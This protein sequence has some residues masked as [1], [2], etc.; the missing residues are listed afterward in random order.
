MKTIGILLGAMVCCPVVGWADVVELVSGERVEGQGAQANGERVTIQVGGQ[1]VEFGRE[2]VRAIF[3]TPIST[4]SGAAGMTQTERAIELTEVD[5]V[6]IKGWSSSQVS[7]YGVRL[8]NSRQMAE[9]VLRQRGI[10]FRVIEHQPRDG[11]PVSAILVTVRGETRTAVVFEMERDTVTKI[12]VAEMGAKLLVG[13]TQKLFRFHDTAT[14]LQLLGE[15][16]RRERGLL[17]GIDYYY[18]K[19]G[20]IIETYIPAV[21]FIVPAKVR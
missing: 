18:L 19:E 3:L 6:R 8:G 4:P 16:D 17:G 11:V 2:K 21:N 13:E 10:T 1:S 14:R 5:L 15:E 20:M 9:D 12:Q 7:L